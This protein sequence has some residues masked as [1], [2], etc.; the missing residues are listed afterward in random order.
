MTEQ[1]VREIIRRELYDLIRTDRYTFGRL[2]QFMEGQNI[3]TGVNSGTKIGTTITQKIGFFGTTPVVQQASIA[4]PA[5]GGTV[6]TQARTAI[7]SILDV[8]DNFGLTA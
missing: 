7:N 3:Q 8:L 1:Q 6:D 4:D 2:V 5:G